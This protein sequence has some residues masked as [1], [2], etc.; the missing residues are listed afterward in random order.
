M[1]SPIQGNSQN[2][3]WRIHAATAKPTPHTGD[4]SISDKARTKLNEKSV[5]THISIINRR[6]PINGVAMDNMPQTG[7]R[8]TTDEEADGISCVKS[9]I[10]GIQ[11]KNELKW[12]R[13]YIEW[14]RQWHQSIICRVRLLGLNRLTILICAFSSFDKR[15]LPGS[16]SMV[17]DCTCHAAVQTDKQN[18]QRK[19]ADDFHGTRAAA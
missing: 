3:S 19:C 10:F 17:D 15:S 18:R 14:N 12:W 5:K 11:P 9:S 4:I 1:N 13:S 6:P 7:A 2:R 8:T 16:S